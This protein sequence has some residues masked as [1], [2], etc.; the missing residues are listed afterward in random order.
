MLHVQA[1]GAQKLCSLNTIWYLN[2]NLL[3]IA[4]TKSMPAN[5]KVNDVCNSL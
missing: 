2:I 1:M 3:S 5:D 4:L